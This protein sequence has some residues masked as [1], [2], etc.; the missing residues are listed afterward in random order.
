MKKIIFILSA[1]W[2]GVLLSGCATDGVY[3]AGK[4]VYVGGKAVVKVL[5]LTEEAKKTLSTVDSV[6]TNY[7]KS[8]TIVKD[9][10][11]GKPTDANTSSP[12]ID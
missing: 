3:N 4:T 9:A 10:I 6:A 8:R 11:E 1:I 5:P 2:A 7:D 12:S